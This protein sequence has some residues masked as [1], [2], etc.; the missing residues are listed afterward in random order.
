M[1]KSIKK[2]STEDKCTCYRCGHTYDKKE[3]Q[4]YRIHERDYTSHFACIDVEIPLCKECQKDIEE[5]WFNEKSI[6]V[7]Y[8]MFDQ[9]IYYGE[10]ELFDF[11]CSFPLKY[12]EKI[13]NQGFGYATE[14]RL[15]PEEWIKQQK[16]ILA[17]LYG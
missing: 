9:Y 10:E 11:I 13:F 12:Q 8:G 5:D 15:S 2:N 7:E 3:I 17:S 1:S 6:E 16:K 14:D 4:K